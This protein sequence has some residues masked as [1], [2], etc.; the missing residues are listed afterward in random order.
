MHMLI[1]VWIC[2][3]VKAALYCQNPL[4]YYVSQSDCRTYNTAPLE[5]IKS[6]LKFKLGP[7]KG[8]W[9]HLNVKLHFCNADTLNKTTWTVM[10]TAKWADCFWECASS[11]FP[12]ACEFLVVH[13]SIHKIKAPRHWFLL[14]S[15]FY[16][17]PL[18]CPAVV[19]IIEG[20]ES[21]LWTPDGQIVQC[22]FAFLPDVTHQYVR[23]SS[24]IQPEHRSPL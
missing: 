23:W 14:V 4:S 8:R 2:S 17:A 9:G 16:N 11:E 19:V 20:H 21:T 12:T 15:G 13:D 7:Y 5:T 1:P 6:I 10:S 18:A 3:L 22:S 24:V